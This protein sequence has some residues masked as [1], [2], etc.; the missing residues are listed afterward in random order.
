MT[1]AVTTEAE[2][3]KQYGPKLPKQVLDQEAKIN[4]A[5]NKRGIGPEPGTVDPVVVEEGATPSLENTQIKVPPSTSDPELVPSKVDAEEV[6]TLKADNDKLRHKLSVLEGKYRSEVPAYAKKLQELT[7]RLEQ[8]E[9]G[10]QAEITEAEAR[11]AEEQR[12][13]D[14]EEFGEDQID[15]IDRRVKANQ[16]GHTSNAEISELRDNV[17]KLRETAFWGSLQNMVPDFQEINTSAP[18]VEW[19]QHVDPFTGVRRQDLLSDAHQNGDALRVA[20]FFNT[21][22]EEVGLERPQGRESGKK[23]QPK[24]SLSVEPSRASGGESPSSQGKRKYT[25]KEIEKFYQ[26]IAIPGR[27]TGTPE[28]AAAIERDIQLAQK[29]G[30][31]SKS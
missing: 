31:I 27:W 8:V 10:K 28:Q 12:A 20:H 16:A 24:P 11:A 7:D 30:R 23:K 21:Y 4:D 17:N 14:I 6:A 18:F 25:L 5:L 1:T 3:K 13:K 9:A 29:E 19:L 15:L 2:A 26:D 22:A